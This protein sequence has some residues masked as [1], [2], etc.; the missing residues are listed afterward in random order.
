M[1]RRALK[2][3][4]DLCV[5]FDVKRDIGSSWIGVA[6][7]TVVWDPAISAGNLSD[8]MTVLAFLDGFLTLL[9]AASLPFGVTAV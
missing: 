7:P 4:L 9:A 1:T 8:F 5:A 2:R 6:C 3:I